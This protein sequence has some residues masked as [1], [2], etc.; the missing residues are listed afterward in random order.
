MKH[1]FF[2][3]LRLL[4]SVNQSVSQGEGKGHIPALHIMGAAE[5][6]KIKTL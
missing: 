5:G 1:I 6:L 4:V 2:S 3:L